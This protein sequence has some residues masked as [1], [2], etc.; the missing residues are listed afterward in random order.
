MKEPENQ[1]L[2]EECVKQD[3]CEQVCTNFKCKLRDI[4]DCVASTDTAT[5]TEEDAVNDVHKENS[6]KPGEIENEEVEVLMEID[7]NEISNT[8]NEVRIYY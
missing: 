2:E 3:I 8:I 5:V 4:E 7:E 1:Q 6:E